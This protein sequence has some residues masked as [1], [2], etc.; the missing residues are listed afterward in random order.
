MTVDIRTIKH[1]DYLEFIVTGTFDLNKAIDQFFLILATCR[2]TGFKKILIDFRELVYNAGGTEKSLYA[3]GTEDQ[4]LKYL[5]SGGHELQIAYLGKM[6]KT[7]EPG[8]EIGKK[9]ESLKVELFDNLNAAIEWL[10]V[11]NI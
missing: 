6:F 7:Y 9:I 5:S 11:K 10:G 4:Y 3:F 8:L 1:T 2:S